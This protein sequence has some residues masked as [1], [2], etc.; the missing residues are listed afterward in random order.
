MLQSTH[1]TGIS[2]PRFRRCSVGEET[3][4][5]FPKFLFLSCFAFSMI[6][7][8]TFSKMRVSH[9]PG[10]SKAHSRVLGI[11]ILTTRRWVS[12]NRTGL[13]NIWLSKLRLLLVGL[14]HR[15]QTF[16]LACLILFQGVAS[17]QQRV[18]HAQV[19]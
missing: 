12:K 13:R 8:I 6:T 11:Q 3:R 19:S 14:D 15:S 18:G 1:L 16:L 5:L 4:M 10:V 9:V 17:G 2:S 7:P